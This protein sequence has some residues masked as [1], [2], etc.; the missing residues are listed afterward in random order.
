MSMLAFAGK[1]C[2]ITELSDLLRCFSSSKIDPYLRIGED[3]QLYVRLQSDLGSYGSES[4]QE[5]AKSMLSDC[6]TKVGINDQRVLDVIASAL[7]NFIEMG[8]DVLTKELTE[9]FTPE[10]MP[11]FGK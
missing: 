7:S 5:V 10:E 4:D 9:M 8:K 2:Q 6:R 3:L 11:L 1:V